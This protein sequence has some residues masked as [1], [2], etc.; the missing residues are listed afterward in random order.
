MRSALLLILLLTVSCAL[1]SQPEL[2]PSVPGWKVTPG[3]RVYTPGDLFDLIDGAADVYLGFGFV[4]LHT[5]EY[6]DASGTSVRVELYRHRSPAYAFG[7]YSGERNT[8]YHFLEIGAQGYLEEGILNFLTGFYYAKLSTSAAGASGSTALT[9]IAHGIEQ[10]LRQPA[11]F[12]AELDLFPS[13]GKIPNAES[14]IGE[15]FLGYTSLH[16][17]FVAEY[18]HPS[19][20]KFF[21]IHASAEAEARAM[22]RGYLREIGADT[23][24]SNPVRALADPHNGPIRVGTAGSFLFGVLAPPSDEIAA[25]EIR[26]FLA[27]A[28]SSAGAR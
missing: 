23:T 4:D 8:D 16:S 2:F 11:G 1:Q 10:A 21:F 25:A 3:E 28:G 26:A 13:I 27:K 15:H 22:L 17:V 6:V 19:S 14:F 18:G 12:P 20:H 7:I 9:T 24:S 5:A